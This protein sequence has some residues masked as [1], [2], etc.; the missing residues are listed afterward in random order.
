MSEQ[1]KNKSTPDSLKYNKD[2]ADFICLSD[3]TIY[4]ECKYCNHSL[5]CQ[6]V[7]ILKGKPVPMESHYCPIVDPITLDLVEWQYYCTGMHDTRSLDE[8]KEGDDK[9]S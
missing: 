5:E 2:C 9:I 1:T 4:R 3:G 6:Q 7:D 8:R